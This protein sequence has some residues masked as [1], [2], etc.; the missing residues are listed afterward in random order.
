[1][2]GRKT[3]PRGP[4]GCLLDSRSRLSTLLLPVEMERRRG[5]KDEPNPTNLPRRRHRACHLS[6][7]SPSLPLFLSSSLSLWLVHSVPFSSLYCLSPQQKCQSKAMGWM[8]LSPRFLFTYRLAST[9]SPRRTRPTFSMASKTATARMNLGFTLRHLPLLQS[10]SEIEHFD[11]GR[12][13][14][15]GSECTNPTVCVCRSLPLLLKASLT[16]VSLPG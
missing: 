2:Q 15:S 6:P 14:G 3:R 5:Y 10:V 16:V 7:P 13:Q 11:R 8:G 1:M 12:T 4:K 9:A